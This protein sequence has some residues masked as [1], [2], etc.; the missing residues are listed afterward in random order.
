MK[1]YWSYGPLHFLAIYCFIVHSI[2]LEPSM[3]MF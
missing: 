3:L 1:F 2:G